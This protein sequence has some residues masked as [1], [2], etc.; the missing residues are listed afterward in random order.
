MLKFL[1]LTDSAKLKYGLEEIKRKREKQLE[2]KSKRLKAATALEVRRKQGI[3]NAGEQESLRVFALDLVDCVLSL[4]FDKID[5]P[6]VIDVESPCSSESRNIVV[7]TKQSRAHRRVVTWAAHRIPAIFMH[8]HPKIYNRDSNKTASLLGVARS[9]VIGW[10]TSDDL[11]SKWYTS[12]KFLTWGKAKQF[13]SEEQTDLFNV[14][15]DARVPEHCLG[16]AP[17]SQTVFVTKSA[18]EAKNGKIL[19][20]SAVGKIIQKQRADQVSETGV[21]KPLNLA[22]IKVKKKSVF[23]CDGRPMKWPE[24][25]VLIKNFV[26]S[27]WHSG[28]PATREQCYDELR[29]SCPEGSPFYEQYLNPS[30]K[31]SQSQ[32]ANWLTRSLTKFG[33]VRRK[34]SISQK[35]PTGNTIVIVY[36]CVNLLLIDWRQQAESWQKK[37]LAFFKR[38][39]VTTIINGDQTF[40]K[41]YHENEYVLCPRGVRRVGRVVSGSNEKLGLTFM[42]T[43]ELNASKILP[44]FLVF[45]GERGKRLDKQYADWPERE[46]HNAYIAFQRKHWFDAPTTLRYLEFIDSLYDDDESIGLV[47]DMAPAHRDTRVAE[48][49]Q[50][51]AERGRMFTF[52]IPGGMTSIL[53]V[54]DLTL[55]APIKAQIKRRYQIWRLEEIRRQRQAGKTGH[56][57]LKVSRPLLIG[58]VE[59]VVRQYNRKD[60]VLKSIERSFEDAGQNVFAHDEVKFVRHLDSLQENTVYDA[61][62]KA[63]VAGD[64]CT[65]EDLRTAAAADKPPAPRHIKHAAAE[66]SDDDEG[67]EID[68]WYLCVTCNRYRKLANE[69][70]G[71]GFTCQSEECEAEC[72][73]DCDC[74]SPCNDF[75]CP[76]SHCVELYQQ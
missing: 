31:S 52:V 56:L 35:V 29:L 6:A 36:A 18:F 43:A 51:Y 63:A 50:K 21:A 26:S 7:V 59:D 20:P 23:Q 46:G 34:T 44:P 61:L 39:E 67:E 5:G 75:D 74:E 1:K 22:I 3:T 38:K 12:V 40:L 57:T 66:S 42:V 24:Q 55:N 10:I 70:V 48:A 2:R 30:K 76:C 16:D 37:M 15:D 45:T 53:Q 8:L 65:D 47:W 71:E 60:R 13:F 33:F 64:I 11:R 28:D 25:F 68:Y 54:C 32:L 19:S 4:V 14:E 58:W 17:G 73:E 9:T 72:E 69:Y 41:F 49:L 62:Y 27:Q